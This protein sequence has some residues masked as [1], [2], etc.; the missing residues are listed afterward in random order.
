M[1][2]RSVPAPLPRPA[3]CD[4]CRRTACVRAVLPCGGQR[5]FCWRH[6]R[7]H[8]DQLRK[9]AADSYPDAA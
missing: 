2:T 8:V 6:A 3:R 4:R 5:L 1:T 9:L 7:L